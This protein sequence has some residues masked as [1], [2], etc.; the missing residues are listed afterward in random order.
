MAVN[1]DKE[2]IGVVG[3]GRNRPP[4]IRTLVLLKKHSTTSTVSCYIVFAGVRVSPALQAPDPHDPKMQPPP[5]ALL[6]RAGGSP[7]GGL[8]M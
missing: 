5:A 2:S 8:E 1:E 3:Y 4:Q 7:V 6:A